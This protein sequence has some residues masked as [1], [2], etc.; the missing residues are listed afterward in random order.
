MDG[1]VLID[2][3]LL[4]G[5]SL[6][7]L[8]A[9]PQISYIVGPPNIVVVDSLAFAAVGFNGSL[10]ATVF[11]ADGNPQETNICPLGGGFA[12]SP[13][14]FKTRPGFVVSA[15]MWSTPPAAAVGYLWVP[16]TKVVSPV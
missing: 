6:A 14:Y 1:G 4:S 13:S 8:P 7:I 5:A 10:V 16:Y 12:A 3:S 2:L 15:V 9:L 11:D